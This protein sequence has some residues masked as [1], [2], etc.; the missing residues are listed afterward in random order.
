VDCYTQ[1]QI[2]E[3][4]LG[5]LEMTKKVFTDIMDDPKGTE[6]ASEHQWKFDVGKCRAFQSSPGNR[7]APIYFLLTL[8]S[9][10]W[11]FF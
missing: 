8:I 4:K 1:D 2:D 5:Q 6:S 7:N 3:T 11:L 10:A 9:F